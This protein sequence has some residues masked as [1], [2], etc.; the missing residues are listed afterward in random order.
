MGNSALLSLS[1]KQFVR[2]KSRT[3]M[4][5]FGIIISITLISGILYATNNLT[6]YSVETQLQQTPFDVAVDS[7]VS[8][9][10]VENGWNQLYSDA[11]INP[12]LLNQM[13]VTTSALFLSNPP[14]FAFGGSDSSVQSQEG[15]AIALNGT[16][17]TSANVN[18]YTSILASNWSL[19]EYLNQ[20]NIINILEF[21]SSANLGDGDILIDSQTAAIHGFTLGSVVSVYSFWSDNTTLSI[22]NLTIVGIVAVNDTTNLFNAFSPANLLSG[23]TNITSNPVGGRFSQIS[24]PS[25]R[26][27]SSVMQSVNVNSTYVFANFNFG[28]QMVANL[29][30]PDPTTFSSTIQYRYIFQLNCAALP[31]FNSNSTEH[32]DDAHRESNCPRNWHNRINDKFHFF[33]NYKHPKPTQLV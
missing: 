3:L 1:G 6:N 10:N 29:S 12:N 32:N 16:V 28:T 23:L 25:S 24:L 18:N 11:S 15:A 14:R 2:N 27:I 4:V 22:E 17:P 9:S 5:M 7:A 33:G 20:T 31:I 13:Y 21:N 8:P 26:L 30:S 19:I